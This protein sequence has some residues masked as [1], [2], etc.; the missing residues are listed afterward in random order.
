MRRVTRQPQACRP[1][2]VPLDSRRSPTRGTPMPK[3]YWICCYQ[4]ITDPGALA[5][6][7]V[8]AGPAIQAGGGRML[9]RGM[10]AKTFEAGK[11]ERTVVIEF[12]SVE[13]AIAT[14]ESAAYREASDKLKNAAVRDIRIVPGAA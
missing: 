5:A 10:P 2:Q 1:G 14:Y 13:Q 4:A 3:G 11:A 12:D 7:A 9:V 8:A 6:Y